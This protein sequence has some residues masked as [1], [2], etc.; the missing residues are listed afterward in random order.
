MFEDIFGD[1]D[2]QVKKVTDIEDTP[3]RVASSEDVWKN[4][5][6]STAEDVDPDSVWGRIDPDYIW[7]T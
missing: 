5:I 1:F 3:V 7:R 4:D 6:W 2:R